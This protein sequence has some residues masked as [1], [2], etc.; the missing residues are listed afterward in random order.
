MHVEDYDYA[1]P[2]SAIAQEAIA[3]RDHSK[4]LDTSVMRDRSFFEL[5]SLLDAGDLVVVNETKVRS[6]RLVGTRATGGRTEVLLIRRI[7]NDRWQALIKPAKNVAAGS[8]IKAEGIAVMLLTNPVDG[9][10]TVTCSSDD[11][12]DIETAIESAGVIPLPPYFHG[13]LRDPS[14]YQTMFATNVGSVAAPTAALHF[15]PAVVSNLAERGI[16]T[17]TVD[18]QVGLDTFRP[19]DPGPDG[20][21]TV[22]SHRIHSERIAVPQATVDAVARARSTDAKVV[23][24]GTTV[25]RSLES[26][27][28]VDG[29]I[30][31]YSGDTDL[32]IRPGYEPRVVDA[33]VTNFHAPR[34]TLLVLVASF[35]GDRWREVYDHALDHD[36][37]FLSFG[38]A[39]YIETDR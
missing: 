1:L 2:D 24:I 29:L 38:D 13:T 28:T 26:A 21:A 10:A 16:S 25:V 12:R 36:Y 9:V 14:R 30:D 11:G 39:M 34:T 31:A 7:D 33:L 4:L 18:L 27:A 3:V 8:L 35:L 19:M 20:S 32:F 37:R 5:P 6:A 17:A 15:T 22:A 23:A